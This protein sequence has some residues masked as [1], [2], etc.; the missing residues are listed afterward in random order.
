[1]P[2]KYPH[3]KWFPNGL[4]DEGQPVIARVT[5]SLDD[6]RAKGYSPGQAIFLTAVLQPLLAR[7]PADPIDAAVV[8]EMDDEM[9]AAKAE[10]RQRTTNAHVLRAEEGVEAADNFLR[11]LQLGDVLEFRLRLYVTELRWA[12]AA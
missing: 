12:P 10:V 3:L 6:L 9:T 1:M 5:R 11:N 2:Q 7:M 4:V 8:R